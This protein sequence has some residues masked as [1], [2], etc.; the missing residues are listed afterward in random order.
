[1]PARAP[2]SARRRR[3]AA[4]GWV[5][6]RPSPAIR[7]RR[8][9][10]AALL[11]VADIGEPALT[12][13]CTS[14]PRRSQSCS[15]RRRCRRRWPSLIDLGEASPI[16]S[17]SV[18][19][20]GECSHLAAF[21]SPSVFLDLAPEGGIDHQD[22]PSVAASAEFSASAATFVSGPVPVSAR[23][24]SGS[25]LV[26]QRHLPARRRHRR[27]SRRFSARSE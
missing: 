2:S 13:R 7:R 21:P 25:A 15:R 27:L 14:A 26:R 8:Q 23:I 17:G 3:P 12:C 9:V 16:R 19:G 1:M 11:L 24:G 4:A 6:R 10:E 20:D 22:R 18:P 5:L